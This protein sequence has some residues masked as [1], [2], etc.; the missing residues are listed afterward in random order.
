MNKIVNRSRL[1]PA[2]VPP[3]AAVSGKHLGE[4][5]HSCYTRSGERCAGIGVAPGTTAIG[6]F[7]DQVR[8]VVRETTAAFV[9]PRNVYGPAA[10]QVARDLH[11]AHKRSLSAHHHRAAPSGAPIRRINDENVRVC[12]IKVVPGNVQSPKEWR[13]R[14]VISPTR[15]AIGRALVE[16]AEMSPA[17]RIIRR[18]GLVSAKTLTAARAIEPDCNPSAR[19]LVVENNRVAKGVVEGALAIGLRKAG[20]G[21]AA[22]GGNRC[23]GNVDGVKVAAA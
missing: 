6:G 8:V 14:I 1:T 3:V 5:A 18:G 13:T 23:A 9:H 16:S 2:L 21:S 7:K 15:F 10:R 11:V 20:K 22:I 17:I 12:S 4:V 19:R